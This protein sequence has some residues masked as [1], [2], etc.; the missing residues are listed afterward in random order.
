[1]LFLNMA[2]VEISR[3]AIRKYL[4]LI[5][6]VY[7]LDFGWNSLNL[8]LNTF[9]QENRFLMSSK[10]YSSFMYWFGDRSYFFYLWSS[11]EYSLCRYFLFELHVG[12]IL[13]VEN[14]QIRNKVLQFWLFFPARLKIAVAMRVLTV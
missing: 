10:C 12:L 2:L 9:L 3:F 7:S 11:V 5:N 6:W 13:A 14:P 4:A 8:S 1:M